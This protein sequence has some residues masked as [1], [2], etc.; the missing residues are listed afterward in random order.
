MRRWIGRGVWVVVLGAALL[1]PLGCGLE[2]CEEERKGDGRRV[3]A[4][5]PKGST[6]EFWKAVHAGA[7]KA[8]GELGVRILWQGPLREDDRDSQIRVVEDMI[9]RQVDGLVLAPLDDTALARPVEEARRWGIP[10]VIIDSRLEWDG[11]VSFVA[12]DNYQGGVLAA[13]HLAALLGDRG[14]VMVMR[15]QEGSASTRERERG[16]LETMTRRFDGI[17]IVSSNQY[18]GSTTESAYAT[19]ERLLV[20]YRAVDGIFT[21]NE[22]TTFGML[23]AV[24]DAGRAGRV[25]HVGFD[26]SAKLIAALEKGHLHGLV[27]QDPFRMGEVGVRTLVAHLDGETV[28]A[29]IDTGVHVATRDNMAE[30]RIAQLLTPDVARWLRKVVPPPGSSFR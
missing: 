30:P 5:V 9:S 18:G 1:G 19:A 28:E 13:E 2:G 21:P 16:F 20:R 3:I 17:E 8:G 12:T 23:R 27:L 14:K 6:H 11:L 29:R 26:S 25:K 7:R 22:S 4:V 10:T 15:Y 24:Q